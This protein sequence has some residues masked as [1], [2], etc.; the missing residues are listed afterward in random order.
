MP[1]LIC[2]YDK[3]FSEEE[4]QQ[5]VAFYESPLGKKVASVLPEIDAQAETMQEVASGLAQTCIGR[6][7]G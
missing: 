7:A 6:G 4:L 1:T 2:I 5:L 3:H